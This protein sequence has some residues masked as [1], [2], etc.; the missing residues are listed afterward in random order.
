MTPSF[1][2]RLAIVALGC[3]VSTAPQAA[4]PEPSLPVHLLVPGFTVKE[5]PVGLTNINNIEYAPD[6]RLFALGYDGRI[7]VLTDTDGDG[8]E[9]TAKVWWKSPVAAMRGPIGMVIAPE[10]I[11]VASKGKVSL[12]HDTKG[13]GVADTEDV[14]TTGWKEIRQN[15]DAVGMALGKDNSLYFCLGCADYSNA[16]L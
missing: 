7:H 5:L 6:G 14:V 10:G 3:F 13:V 1:F 9:D 8:I 15:V 11:Y 4:L 2:C 16:Y 12:F